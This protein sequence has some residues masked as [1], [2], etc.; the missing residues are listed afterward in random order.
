MKQDL[1]AY[2]ER[3]H[4]RRKV[5]NLLFCVALGVAAVVA[6]SPLF[7]VFGYVLARG[8]PALNLEFLTRL[9][10]PVGEV[11]GGMANALVGTCILIGLASAIGIPWGLGAAIY[12]SEY[13]RG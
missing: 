10:Q 5:K 6:L 9:P 3:T 4:R 11:G 7:S 2:I 8:G 1:I 13:G 12:L